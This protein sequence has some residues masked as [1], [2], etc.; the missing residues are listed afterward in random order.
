MS[1]TTIRTAVRAGLALVGTVVGFKTVTSIRDKKVEPKWISELTIVNRDA[2][3][4]LLYLTQLVNNKKVNVDTGGSTFVA[5]DLPVTVQ[6]IYK[7][8]LKGFCI[9]RLYAGEG[10]DS[11]IFSLIISG[12]KVNME[13]FYTG[14][15]WYFYNEKH[16][17]SD[18][19]IL[20]LYRS[21]TK[22]LLGGN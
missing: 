3:E 19:E 2:K 1:T 22:T 5:Y 11:D 15:N 13:I 9:T 4:L 21:L 14:D 6:E 20:T 10:D 16:I 17:S 8:I 12:G 7:D 18:E